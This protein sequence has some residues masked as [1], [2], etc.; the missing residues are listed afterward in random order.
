M[1]FKC[2]YISTAIFVVILG[3]STPNAQRSSNLSS[4]NYV[5]DSDA[6]ST[7][8][9]I[10]TETEE[11]VQAPTKESFQL[12]NMPDFCHGS[13][14]DEGFDKGRFCV[15]CRPR[16]L[17]LIR[18]L[19]V[20]ENY[21]LKEASN[22]CFLS[23]ISAADPVVSCKVSDTLK[24]DML[25]AKNNFEII[26][27][28]YPK[29]RDRVKNN[30]IMTGIESEED[31]EL[32]FEAAI[33]PFKNMEEF[34]LAERPSED[35]DLL[36]S[37]L[38]KRYP[39]SDESYAKVK[40]SIIQFMTRFHTEVVTKDTLSKEFILSACLDIFF[41]ALTKDHELRKYFPVVPDEQL[42]AYLVQ[43]IANF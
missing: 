34:I 18:C 11:Q 25:L 8:S 17:P 27:E 20:A 14:K 10:A 19:D 31:R 40:E 4:N 23:D 29:I 38:N 41:N 36:L 12:L 5:D 2:F 39:L 24:F 33:F 16:T 42:N 30:L 15:I 26:Y 37:L 35:A 13:I 1:L 22:A 6:T 28:N 21:S 7:N 3:C 43:Y 32:L 9:S